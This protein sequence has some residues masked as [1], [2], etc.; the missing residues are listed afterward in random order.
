[1][2]TTLKRTKS[3]RLDKRTKE[4]KEAAARMAKVRAARGGLMTRIK[5]LF[6]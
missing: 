1:M 3:G 6:S 5:K 4:G 2:A